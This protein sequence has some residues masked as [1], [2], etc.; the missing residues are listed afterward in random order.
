MFNGEYIDIDMRDYD[1]AR[2]RLDLIYATTDPERIRIRF[3]DDRGWIYVGHV[4]Y[5]VRETINGGPLVGSLDVT[6]RDVI[7]RII[8]FYCTPFLG[9]GSAETAHHNLFRG[10][11]FLDWVDENKFY[12]FYSD[13]VKARD[14][15]RGFFQDIETMVYERREMESGTGYQKQKT[16][17]EAFI[18]IHNQS[19]LVFQQ[20]D[21]IVGAKCTP[22]EAAEQE[23]V[24][25]NFHSSRAIFEGISAWL[26]DNGKFPF[27]LNLPHEDIWVV[28]SRTWSMPSWIMQSRDGRANGNWMWNYS[29]GQINPIERVQELYGYSRSDAAKEVR[30]AEGYV[31][32]I[33]CNPRYFLRLI[34]YN[35]CC[36]AF[37]YIFA[38]FT[39]MNPQQVKKQKW[40]DDWIIEAASNVEG[41]KF[42]NI[43]SRANKFVAF[44]LSKAG[45]PLLERYLE[46]RKRVLS[47][48]PNFDLLFFQFDKAGE[49][50]AMPAQY[51]QIYYSQVRERLDPKINE[52]STRKMRA[53]KG[54]LISEKYSPS[55]AAS[56]LQNAEGTLDRHYTNGNASTQ[57]EEFLRYYASFNAIVFSKCDEVIETI[58]VGGCAN[59]GHP[60]AISENAEVGPACNKPEGCLGCKHFRMH[61]DALD[62]KK[63]LSAKYVLNAMAEYLSD[64]KEFELMFRPV[65][66]SI[67]SLVTLVEQHSPSL[68]SVVA[69]VTASV[70][71]GYLTEYWEDKLNF[72]IDIGILS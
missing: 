72:L 27:L 20:L 18:A 71:D 32:E 34:I 41:I 5:R 3:L 14:V 28:V 4:G 24:N 47:D 31:T 6:R 9:G 10:L 46:F 22:T 57:S 23:E 50:Q 58:D 40:G 60:E 64:T 55:D 45:V 68:A 33:N 70:N 35:L 67:D 42:V 15:L 63:V 13:E 30:R 8:D 36:K 37:G 25:Y 1:L 26:R 53:L 7:I 2:E 17:Y 49:I 29:T 61:A 69:E 66:D 65:I 48:Y 21:P 19:S 56:A 43:K 52:L 39:V 51:L 44:K 12:D 54:Y 11:R 16:A 59:Y 38:A 62:L